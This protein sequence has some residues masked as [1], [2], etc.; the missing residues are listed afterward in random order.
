MMVSLDTYIRHIHQVLYKLVKS[1]NEFEVRTKEVSVTY[2]I[3][4]YDIAGAK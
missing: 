2:C 1:Q 3:L 4:L